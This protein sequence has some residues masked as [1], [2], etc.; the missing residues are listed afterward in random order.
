ASPWKIISRNPSKKAKPAVEGKRSST[1][2]IGSRNPGGDKES[3]HVDMI[4]RNPTETGTQNPL[5][6]RTERKR[7]NRSTVNR[8]LYSEKKR[9]SLMNKNATRTNKAETQ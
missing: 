8:E 5:I 6:K 9:D 3:P 2:Q 7:N 4:N 1:N